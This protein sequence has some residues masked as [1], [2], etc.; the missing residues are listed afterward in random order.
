MSGN[1]VRRQGT[2]IR[3]A[4][5]DGFFPRWRFG[6]GFPVVALVVCLGSAGGQESK[7]AAAPL[8]ERKIVERVT[9]VTDR[10]LA[11]LAAVQRRDGSWHNNHAVNAL[12]L[13]AYMGRGHVPGRGP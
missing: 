4:S 12:A 13:L 8:T 3:S 2:Q 11:Y 6:F 9:G 5:E 7:P 1:S 10:A